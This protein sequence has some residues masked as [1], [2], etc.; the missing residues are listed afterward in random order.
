MIDLSIMVTFEIQEFHLF[1]GLLPSFPPFP[2]LVAIFKIQ[3]SK[4]LHFSNFWNSFSC[5]CS[6]VTLKMWKMTKMSFSCLFP[7]SFFMISN[8]KFMNTLNRKFYYHT[9]HNAGTFAAEQMFLSLHWQVTDLEE[10]KSINDYLFQLSTLLFVALVANSGEKVRV[11][12]RNISKK[13]Q[14]LGNY[15]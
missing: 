8:L 10:I 9:A 3:I 11:I 2:S 7:S 5:F 1:C 12:V 15:L 13:A 4:C 6:H 14:L